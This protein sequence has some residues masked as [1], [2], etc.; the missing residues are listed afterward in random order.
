MLDLVSYLDTKSLLAF[1]QTCKTIDDLVGHSAKKDLTH[2]IQDCW[3]VFY[4]PARLKKGALSALK[5]DGYAFLPPGTPL[6]L[7]TQPL[8]SLESLAFFN[9]IF[10]THKENLIDADL[11]CLGAVCPLALMSNNS[12]AHFANA[13]EALKKSL[14][15]SFHLS[16]FRQRLTLNVFKWLQHLS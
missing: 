12:K 1:S 13:L 14:Q 6:P 9:Q 16:G 8:D 5:N 4:E 11:L 7:G 2:A 3:N 15:N 10:S